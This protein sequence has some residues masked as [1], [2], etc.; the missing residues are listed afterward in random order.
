MK[1]FSHW[2]RFLVSSLALFAPALAISPAAAQD[3]IPFGPEVEL[4]Q[5]C[6]YDPLAFETDGQAVG[7]WWRRGSGIFARTL[8]SFDAP[9]PIVQLNPD[10]VTSDVAVAPWPGGFAAAWTR[11]PAA[12]P[13][14]VVLQGFGANLSPSFPPVV[15]GAASTF[16]SPAL[17]AAD[18]QLVLAYYDLTGTV[19]IVRYSSAGAPL[20]PAIAADPTI[21]LGAQGR[22]RLVAG[23]TGFLVAW[24]GFRGG[25]N[26]KLWA[27]AFGWDGVPAAA[28]ADFVQGETADFDVAWA[29]GSYLVALPGGFDVLGY[30]LDENG[31]YLDEAFV[32]EAADTHHARFAAGDGVLW[33]AFVG[34]DALLGSRIELP[35]LAVDPFPQVLVPRPENG[36]RY[37][38]RSSA[39]P[40][41]EGFLAAWQMAPVNVIIHPC[42]DT[43]T[44]YAR[45]FGP[46]RGV[47]DVPVL[48]PPGLLA[49][50][51]LVAA[52]GLLLLRR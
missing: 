2:R 5:D 24:S 41:T 19:Q 51:L 29:G 12:Q 15:V 42:M 38:A 17:L 44:V 28:T 37:I 16:P 46:P 49:L 40:S 52:G 27:R 30:R 33:L 8:P 7:L 48:A 9:G 43:D 31:N 21:L 47:V 6:T 23:E 45:A 26:P 50:A 39:F 36:Q 25:E 3:L 4:D 18:G 20:G 1:H 14:E 11:F 32:I 22:I 10:V 13:P 35:S 34:N